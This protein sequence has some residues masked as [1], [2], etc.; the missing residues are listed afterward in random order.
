MGVR[1]DSEEIVEVTKDSEEIVEVTKDSKEIV[2]FPGDCGSRGDS[3]G[4]VVFRG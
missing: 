4:T 3:E 1:K 2:I